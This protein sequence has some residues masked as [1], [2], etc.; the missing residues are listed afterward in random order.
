MDVKSWQNLAKKEG[1]LQDSKAWGEKV[2]QLGIGAGTKV[3]IYGSSLPDTGRVWWTLKYL[4]LQKVAI[5][6][7]GW[8]L[9]KM[10]KRPVDAA[11]P[12]LHVKFKTK[13]PG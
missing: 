13:Y 7:G 12:K 6:D 5:L 1:G 8:G 11:S 10:E 9:W 3:V 2:G 4:G